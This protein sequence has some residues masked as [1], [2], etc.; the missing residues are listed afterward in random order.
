MNL[1]WRQRAFLSSKLA[2]TFDLSTIQSRRAGVAGGRV[3][4]IASVPGWR[5][6][7]RR[8]ASENGPDGDS[9]TSLIVAIVLDSSIG[10]E[11]GANLDELVSKGGAS[12]GVSGTRQGNSDR[13]VH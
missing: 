7:S 9:D 12:Q 5:A 10:A 11:D 1:D 2:E 6:G 13:S 8:D 4:L 3:G